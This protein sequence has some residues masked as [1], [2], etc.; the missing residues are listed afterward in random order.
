M[1]QFIRT[2]LTSYFRK[3]IL[4][5]AV[6]TARITESVK[7]D[8]RTGVRRRTEEGTEAYCWKIA[9]EIEITSIVFSIRRGTS[10]LIRDTIRISFCCFP[11][12]HHGQLIGVI[13]KG[14]T[15]ESGNPQSTGE[16]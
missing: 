7:M 2:G 10:V 14:Q 12:S 8:E 6:R 16:Q 4:E 3:F 11:V 5:F 9:H 1:R 15:G 13:Y